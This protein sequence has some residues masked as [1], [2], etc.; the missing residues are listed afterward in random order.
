MAILEGVN[1]GKSNPPTLMGYKLNQE[2][3]TRKVLRMAWTT[4]ADHA[5][6]YRDVNHLKKHETASGQDY[7]RF[8]RERATL[9]NYNDSK[10]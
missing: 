1:T 8:K 2:A 4:K 10:H 6:T 3:N 9:K 5:N 7:A